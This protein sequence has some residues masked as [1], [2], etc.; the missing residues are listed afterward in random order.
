MIENQTHGIIHRQNTGAFRYH[1]W[2]TVAR[3]TDGTLAAACSGG[4]IWHICPFGKS[5]LFLSRDEG[6]S[7]SAPIVV[8]DTWMDDRDV[9]LTA[10]PNGGLLMSWFSADFSL[11]DERKK[12]LDE[13]YTEGEKRLVEGYREACLQDA[14]EKPGS[15]LRVS[16]DGGLT[17][18]ETIRVDV[19][20][21]HGPV[22]LADGSL[23]Y[24]AKKSEPKT[25]RLICA[26][27]STDNGKTW[28][29]LGHPPLPEHTAW[30]N[31][32][33]PHA[34]QLPSGRIAGAI[35]YEATPKNHFESYEQ[36][37][38]FVTVSDDGGKSWSVPKCLGV[39]GSPPHLM[40]HSSGALVLSYGRREDGKENYDLSERALISWDEGETWTEDLAIFEDAP[41]WDLGYPSTVELSDGT[42]LTAFYQKYRENGKTD[43]KGSFLFTKWHLVQGGNGE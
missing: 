18:G 26:M 33:E 27:H 37:T 29:E 21:P 17:W 30:S 9:G 25:E 16:L 40:Y 13:V 20:A 36:L 19:S 39:S 10:L 5:M 23:L 14:E 11:L 22:L 41:D 12:T 24:F 15:F 1:A 8:N 3:L 32:Y 38:M 4:R 28:T 7:W 35:R 43:K 6:R 34:V 2:G 42:L 31:F